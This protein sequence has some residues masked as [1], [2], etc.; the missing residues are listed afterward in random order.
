[1]FQNSFI[2]CFCFLI[3]I[4]SY[5]ICLSTCYICSIQYDPVHFSFIHTPERKTFFLYVHEYIVYVVYSVKVVKSNWCETI[6][7]HVY[8]YCTMTHTWLALHTMYTLLYMYSI[9]LALD[10]SLYCKQYGYILQMIPKKWI[11]TVAKFYY[12][13]SQLTFLYY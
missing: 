11:P 7:T 3:L 5:I 2:V 10:L 6:L 12:Y 1:M 9:C 13:Q 4:F 8:N